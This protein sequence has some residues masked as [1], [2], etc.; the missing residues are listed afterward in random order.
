VLCLGTGVGGAVLLTSRLDRELARRLT[1]EAVGT[2]LLVAIVVG[3][4]IAAQRLSPGQTGLQLLINALVTG[5]GLVA[6][7]LAL[8]PISGGHFNPVVTLADRVLGGI[9]TGS[10]LAYATV[11]VIG[12]C[13]GAVV[14][15]LMFNLPAVTIST[16]SRSSSGLLLGEFV[17]TFGLVLVILGVVRSGRSSVAA[18][19]VGGYITAAYWFTSS[20]SFANPAVTVGRT[21]SNTFAGI[22]PASAPAFIAMQVLGGLAAVALARFLRPSVPADAVVVPHDAVKPD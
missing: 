16:H 15:N 1:A 10:A 4:G 2:A 18:F 5:A 3:S 11:Q 20:T 8:G 14:A 22:R 19:A 13:V 17:A 21:L 7:I 12:A 6:L 9:S